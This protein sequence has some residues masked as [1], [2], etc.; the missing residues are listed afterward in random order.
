MQTAT[1]SPSPAGLPPRASF[2]DSS[3]TIVTADAR[4]RELAQA[5]VRLNAEGECTEAALLR[6][7]FSRFELEHLAAAARGLADGIFVRHDE[8]PR[9]TDADLLAIALEAVPSVSN[10]SDLARALR[11]KLTPDQLARTWPKFCTTLAA[12]IAKLPIPGE[13]RA[14][15]R[16]D[17][18]SEVPTHQTNS[19][20]S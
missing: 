15:L 11:G 5:M 10:G 19:G 12:R 7:G 1:V 8:T 18:H 9:P 14:P 17:R 16:D 2:P 6:E 20:R 13:S 4:T 3:R